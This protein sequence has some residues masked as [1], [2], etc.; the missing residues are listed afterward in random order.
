MNKRIAKFNEVNKIIP[1]SQFGFQPGL[2]TAGAITILHEL[3]T[4]S[5][6]GKKK[7][8]AAFVDLQKAFDYTPNNTI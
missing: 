7:V 2:S 4:D 8:Y 1:E 5:L 3:V 6:Q